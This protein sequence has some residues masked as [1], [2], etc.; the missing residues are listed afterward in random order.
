MKKTSLK[1]AACI[2]GSGLWYIFSQSR[3][4]TLSIDVPLCFYGTDSTKLDAPEK[5]HIILSGKRSDLETIDLNHLAVHIDATKLNN[6]VSILTIE[7][8]HLF[9]PATIKLVHYSPAPI[10]IHG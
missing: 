2:I 10:E 8:H 1:I 3:I 4:D 6:K 9:L 5:V 7:A